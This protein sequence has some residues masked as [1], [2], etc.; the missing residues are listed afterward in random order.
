M[1]VAALH[2]NAS[3]IEAWHL[4]GVCAY[5]EGD[6]HQA[7]TYFER[8]I[9][10]ALDDAASAMTHC[11]LAETLRKLHQPN[12]GLPHALV[13][14]N[15]TRASEFSLRVLSWLYI[16]LNMQDNAADILQQL[17]AIN[18]NDIDAWHSLGS[19]FAYESK[20]PQ[21]IH[22]FSRMLEIDPH[23]TRGFAGLGQALHLS[24]DLA[25]AMN[26]YNTALA[27]NAADVPTLQGL[28]VLYQ[29]LGRLTEAIAIYE[30]I[31]RE[32]PSNVPVLNNLGAALKYVNR[33]VESVRLLETSIQLDPSNTQGYVN[34]AS[35]YEE[36]G[37]LDKARAMLTKAYDISKADILRIHLVIMLPQVYTSHEHLLATRVAMEAGIDDLL[38][39]SL[40][41]DDPV[42]FE[43]RP[44]FYLVYQGMNDVAIQTKLAR[45]YMQSCPLLTFVAPHTKHGVGSLKHFDESPRRLR[46]GFMSKFFVYNHAHGLLLRGILAHLNRDVFEIVLLAVPDP[47]QSVDPLMAAAADQVKVLS[48]HLVHVQQDIAALELDVLVFADI[49]SEPINYFTAFSRLAH[50]Q[51]AFWGNPTMS[52]IPNID[53]F[54]SADNMESS[55]DPAVESHYSE[56]VVLLSGLGIWYDEI[57]VP[58]T[59][60]NH[61]DYG[62][63]PSWTV[64]MC[65]QSV[66]KLLPSFDA[67]LIEILR[68]DPAGHLVLLQARRLSWTQQ[69]Q[70]RL[71]ATMPREMHDRVHFVPRVAGNAP[72]LK[73]LSV[74]DVVL[75]PFPFGGSKTSADALRLGIPLVAMKTPFLR[76][77]MA[78]SFFVHMDILDCIATSEKEYIDKVVRL[79]TDR[80]YHDEIAQR[81]KAKQSMLWESHQVVQEWERFL[82]NAVRS[83]AG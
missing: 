37:D 66:Y 31:L 21:A 20:L 41:I 23:D 57:E 48:M 63:D 16:D 44:P 32:Q 54:I 67:V 47:Q 42:D 71:A 35:Y 68:R 27:I 69:F 55:P 10:V 79:G 83:L 74:A 22:A 56:Q 39:D 26:A 62:L 52:G 72:F 53:Y 50:V 81:I 17:V 36:E 13:C 19:V 30:R 65:P 82:Y 33:R 43:V 64:Y 76:S 60:G 14:H 11:N 8:G 1:Y 18:Q 51:A 75:H 77:R 34:L 78:Y 2:E 49:M 61:S 4:L 28:A 59:L 12:L 15:K 45:L 70:A 40:S 73:L 9:E 58:A 25:G 80:L 38:N 7:Q 3:N 24:G 5:S 6:F 46:I 29:Q